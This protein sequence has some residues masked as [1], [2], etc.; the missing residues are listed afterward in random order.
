MRQSAP[1]LDKNIKKVS[2]NSSFCS[3]AKEAEAEVRVAIIAV[4]GGLM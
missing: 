3:G 1:Q 2:S 4:D